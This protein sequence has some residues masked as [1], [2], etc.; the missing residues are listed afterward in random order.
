[1]PQ[2]RCESGR[3]GLDTGKI[4]VIPIGL[5]PITVAIRVIIYI[6]YI[7]LIIVV[8]LSDDSVGYIA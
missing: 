7:L 6:L 4:P 1:L 3:L 5:M 8:Y 2:E